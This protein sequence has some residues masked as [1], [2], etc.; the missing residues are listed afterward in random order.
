MARPKKVRVLLTDEGT[1]KLNAIRK[2]RS[3][4][5]RMNGIRT[6]VPSPGKVI[7]DIVDQA[8]HADIATMQKLANEAGAAAYNKVL[9]EHQEAFTRNTPIPDGEL[10]QAAKNE[11]RQDMELYGADV[12]E[13]VQPA[14]TKAHDDAVAATYRRL[15]A[16]AEAI[17]QDLAEADAAED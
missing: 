12:R 7:E 13:T 14:A 11:F 4:I 16:E 10:D 3:A 8:Y 17:I 9:T 15:G 2:I 5:L 6:S 1:R